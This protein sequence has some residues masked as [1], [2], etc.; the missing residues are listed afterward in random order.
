MLRK[1][2]RRGVSVGRSGSLHSPG[3]V[4]WTRVKLSCD[5][6]GGSILPVEYRPS[7]ALEQLASERGVVRP[8]VCRAR[9]PQSSLCGLA[10]ALHCVS[11]SALLF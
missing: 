2:S 9:G 3:L 4:T 10:F 1:S 6:T 11:R 7:E 8:V 5:L